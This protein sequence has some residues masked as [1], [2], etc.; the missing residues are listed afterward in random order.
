MLESSCGTEDLK[1][2]F[3]LRRCRPFAEAWD[4]RDV[5]NSYGL[6]LQAL[7]DKAQRGEPLTEDEKSIVCAN[8]AW[9][10]AKGLHIH[11]VQAEIV[12]KELA[13]LSEEE[14]RK[15][16]LHMMLIVIVQLD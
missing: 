14:R 15:K 2:E 11:P 4:R 10:H 7:L 3:L 13:S 12:E 16:M 8:A 9:R 5:T 6:R 1:D